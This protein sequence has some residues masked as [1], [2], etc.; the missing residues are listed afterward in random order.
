MRDEPRVDATLKRRR[1]SH[2]STEVP[3]ALRY[4][5][6]VMSLLLPEVAVTG[7]TNHPSG[8]GIGRFSIAAAIT[9]GNRSGVQAKAG[10]PSAASAAACSLS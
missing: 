5:W 6:V 8:T 1:Y 10:A 9:S 4:R 3:Q 7:S 2:G